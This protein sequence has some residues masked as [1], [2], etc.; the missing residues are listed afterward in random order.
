MAA[1]TASLACTV[2]LLAIGLVYCVVKKMNTM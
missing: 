2:L 1:V